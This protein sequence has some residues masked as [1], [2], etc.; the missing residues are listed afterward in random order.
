MA[1]TMQTYYY[2]LWT[3]KYTHLDLYYYFNEWMLF[4]YA[5]KFTHIIDDIRWCVSFLK[6]FIIF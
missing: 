2:I 6:A 4:I 3:H 5:D 1:N